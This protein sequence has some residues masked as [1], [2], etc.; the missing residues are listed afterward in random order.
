M[1][2]VADH[3]ITIRLTDGG[4]AKPDIPAAMKVG[5]T[6]RYTS[7][8]GDLRIVFPNGSPFGDTG[9]DIAEIRGE[10]TLTL[11]REGVFLCR[12]FITPSG[13]IQEVGWDPVASP[14]SG[15]EHNVGH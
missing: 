5:E 14:Q 1:P 9:T 6:V 8:D 10:R 11:Q 12:C 4:H 2:G 7:S 3:E 13:S 15:G